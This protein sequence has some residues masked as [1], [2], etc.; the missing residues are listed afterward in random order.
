ME[1]SGFHINQS[2]IS[3]TKLILLATTLIIVIYLYEKL[4]VVPLIRNS[5]TNTIAYTVE[6]ILAGPARQGRAMYST[7]FMI[8]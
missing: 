4:R 7:Q 2:L 8:Q 1:K 5:L 6:R 3:N